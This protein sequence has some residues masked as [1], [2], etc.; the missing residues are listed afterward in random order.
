MSA[1]G[2]TTVRY[3]ATDSLGNASDIGAFDVRLDRTVPVSND[4]APTTWVKGTQSV[5]LSAADT[6]SGVAAIDYS[7]DG[8]TWGTYSAPVAVAGEGIHTL[9]YHAHD[10]AGN[11]DA[12]KTAT[13]RVDNTAPVTTGGVLESYVGSATVAL[14]ATD[15]ASGVSSTRW[16][17]DGGDWIT[18]ATATATLPGSHAIEWFS[19]DAVGNQESTHIAYFDVLARF[20][21][22][23]PRVVYMGTWS[24]N[25]NTSRVRRRVEDGH[26]RDPEGLRHL[27]RHPL[28]AD[29]LHRPGLRHRARH[30][31]RRDTRLRRPLQLRLQTP[32]EGLLQVRSH[33]RPAHR[34]G[35]VDRYQERVVDG[36]GHRHR[37][38]RRRRHPGR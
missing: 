9:S 3:Q 31:R 28:R 29:R 18:G 2:T 7:L 33:Q 14:G 6:L 11:Q 37:R 34:G 20:D 16:R 15:A 17:L 26:R 21:D 5:T 25:S 23:D 8:G 4:N 35:R 38:R 30:D 10:F 36:H 12:T 19:V 27:H 32:P 13:V 22:A 1:E 24:P